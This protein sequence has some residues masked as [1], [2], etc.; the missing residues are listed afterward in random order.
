MLG[1]QEHTSRV[2]VHDALPPLQAYEVGHRVTTQTRVI[3]HHITLAEAGRCL[4]HSKDMLAA[5]AIS[6]EM[7]SRLG[8]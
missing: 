5:P 2:D 8:S 4:V 6:T 3:D 7:A 1:A